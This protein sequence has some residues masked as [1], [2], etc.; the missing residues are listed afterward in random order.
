[1]AVLRSVE[2]HV[3]MARCANTGISGFIDSSG[4]ILQVTRLFEEATM[5]GN[6]Q[7]GEGKSLYTRYGDWFAWSSFIVTV[8]GFGYAIIGRRKKK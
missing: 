7:L 5:V 2:N 4:H 8:F 3:P 6:I 1:M